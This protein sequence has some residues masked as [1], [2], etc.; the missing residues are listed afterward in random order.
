MPVSTNLGHNYW[1][2]TAVAVPG[3]ACAWWLGQI[4]TFCSLGNGRSEIVPQFPL[5]HCLWLG[6]S[7][8]SCFEKC[9][10][11]LL[12][13]MKV[14]S[15]FLL[16][17][18]FKLL[19]CSM[20]QFWFFGVFLFICLFVFLIPELNFSIYYENNHRTYPDSLTGISECPKH[21]GGSPHCILL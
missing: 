11:N 4:H 15:L 20:K 10:L 21:E 16:N 13:M 1:E 2:C 17:G 8:D 14:L 5:F 18:N 9:S 19:T 6:V 7:F 3:G 12:C